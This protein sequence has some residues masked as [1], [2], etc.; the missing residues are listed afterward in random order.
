MFGLDMWE[1]LLIAVVTFLLF[2]PE[3]L[4]E[5]MRTLARFSRML[6]D[7]GGELQREVLQ[8]AR[9]VEREVQEGLDGT[10]AKKNDP[11]LR[12]PGTEAH[13]LLPDEAASSL[14]PEKSASAKPQGEGREAATGDPTV[15]PG[16]ETSSRATGPAD[17]SGG[18]EI[19]AKDV[20]P[21]H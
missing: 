6:K 18:P 19:L 12:P 9:E 5:L 16:H 14:E 21:L 4:P 3:R 15:T 10:P 8:A 11:G 17:A 13:S 20:P 1:V 7:L 2:G